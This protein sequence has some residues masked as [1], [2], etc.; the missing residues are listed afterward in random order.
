MYA[1]AVRRRLALALKGDFDPYPTPPPGARLSPFEEHRTAY[2]A[3]PLALSWDKAGG[4]AEAW[5]DQLRGKLAGLCGYRRPEQAPTVLHREAAAAPAAGLQRERIYLR[6]WPD[7]DIPLDLVWRDGIAEPAPL[8][9]CLQGTNAGAHLSWGE[10]RMPPDPVKIAAGLDF[11]CQAAARGYVAVC[12]EQRAFGERREQVLAPRSADPCIDAALHSLLLGRTLLG[13]RVSDVSAVLDWLADGADDLPALDRERTHVLGHSA[14]GTVAL[15]AAALDARI[16]A[17]IASGC[18]GPIRD[19]FASRRDSGGQNTI[20]GQLLWC[21]L[22]DVVGLV[23]PRRLLVTSGEQDHIFPYAGAAS[24]VTEA[25]AVYR[26]T[27]HGGRLRS[28]AHPGGHKFDVAR[29]WPAFED[30][31]ADA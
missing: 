1:L 2:D 24:V 12:L 9:L 6:A 14:G 20:P 19:T 15:H 29:V 8:M 27:G 21:E 3:A 30:L 5:Q 23:A 25:M 4:D 7:A 26:A 13:E 28:V 10:T 31:L 11:A 16:D 17:T 22:S 18:I